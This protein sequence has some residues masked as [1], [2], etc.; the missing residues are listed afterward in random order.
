MTSFSDE[1]DLFGAPPEWPAGFRYASGCLD[2]V[3]ADALL[4]EIRRLPFEP[5]VFQGY[6]AKRRVV[7]FGWRYD[8]EGGRLVPAGTIPE[9]LLDTRRAAATFAG[10]EAEDLAHVLV[11]EYEPGAEIGWHKDRPQ[12]GEV[13]GLS[14]HA[15]ATFRL[16]R[17]TGAQWERTSVML[18]PRSA[19]VLT[20]PARWQ[21]EHSIPA[22][23]RLRYS[24]TFRT[25]RSR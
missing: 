23:E 12:F 25:L 13:V 14:L 18:E 21:W 17:K 7:S 22:V 20:G 15:P 11:T 2:A 3:R 10:L 4:N 6:V 5:F 9:F 8:F 24:L 19:Y 16:R 1:T